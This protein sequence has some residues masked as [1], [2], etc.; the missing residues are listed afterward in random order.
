MMKTIILILSTALSLTIIANGKYKDS[1]CLIVC[2]SALVNGTTVGDIT[3][4]LYY[5]NREIDSQNLSNKDY[6]FLFKLERNHYYTVKILK[7]G[8]ITRSVSI[9][10][11]LPAHI[12]ITP[13]F[14]F[15][16]EVELLRETNKLNYEYTDF[17]IAI[18]EYRA[19][20]DVFDYSRKYTEKVKSNMA[21]DRDI[22]Y[23]K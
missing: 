19:G 22:F 14:K 2:G 23:N 7:G 12:S 17:P 1:T 15:H 3:A 18:V 5:D 9:N 21:S 10:T 11:D 4:K 13:V 6:E 16:F 20:R 8:F